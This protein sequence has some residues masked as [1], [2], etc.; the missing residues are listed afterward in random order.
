MNFKKFIMATEDFSTFKKPIPA[1]ILRKSFSLSFVPEKANLYIC[2]S[3]LYEL[4]INGKNVT[5][6]YLCPS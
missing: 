6:G 5:K 2:V 4:Y 1:P 3:G